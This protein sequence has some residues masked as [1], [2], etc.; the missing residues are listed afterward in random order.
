MSSL[1]T[2]WLINQYGSTPETAMGGRHYYLAQELA[3]KGYN[4]YLVA[5][6]YSHLL[7]QPKQFSEPYLLEKI[8]TNFFF[9]CENAPS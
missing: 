6:R 3:K 2:I 5:G 7:R 8:D 1:Q 9:V 4:V